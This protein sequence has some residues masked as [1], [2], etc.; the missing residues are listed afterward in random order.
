MGA[1]VSLSGCASLSDEEGASGVTFSSEPF[2]ALERDF[3]LLAYNVIANEGNRYE[4]IAVTLDAYMRFYDRIAGAGIR[5]SESLEYLYFDALIKKEITNTLLGSDREEADGY[6]R[7]ALE[8]ARAAAGQNIRFANAYS[9]LASI[10]NQSFNVVGTGEGLGTLTLSQKLL[11]RALALDADNPSAWET[12]GILYLYT[13]IGYGGDYNLAINA[14]A[15]QAEHP[16][17]YHKF[18][19]RIWLSLSYFI[20]GRRAEALSTIAE[21]RQEAPQSLFLNEFAAAMESGE[22]P[23]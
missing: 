6:Y 1:L 19:G 11:N 23:F 2:L 18:W 13:P 4:D 20:E 10:L 17:P 14:F 22:R 21:L 8:S 15:M 9:L 16:Y 12:R 7:A 3:Y 5:D